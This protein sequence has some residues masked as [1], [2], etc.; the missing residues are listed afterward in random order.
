MSA[1]FA[2]TENPTSS[3]DSAASTTP[4]PPGVRG[5]AATTLAKP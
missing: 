2:G 3:V 4:R 1:V 5:I